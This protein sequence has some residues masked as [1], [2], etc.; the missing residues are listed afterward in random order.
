MSLR[1]KQSLAKRNQILDSA[2]ALIRQAGNTDFSM[3][4]LAAAAEVAPA[5]PYNFF[6]SK[7]GL[8]FELLSR[9]LEAFMKGALVSA[10]EDPID[11]VLDRADKA[12]TILTSDPVFLRPLYQ[13]MLGLTDPIHHPAFIEDVFVFYRRALD[14]MLESKLLGDEHEREILACALMSHFMGILDLWV[15]RDIEDHD[16]FRAQIAYGFTHL[17]WP[18]ARGKSLT[19]LKARYAEIQGVLAKSRIRPAF[20]GTG[21]RDSKTLGA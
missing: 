7:E 10:K 15:Q 14:D 19:L 17:L 4:V 16:W 8:L 13:V 9:S 18:F 20:L 2:E 21:R 6:G 5:T 1:A 3:R 11:K 12:V